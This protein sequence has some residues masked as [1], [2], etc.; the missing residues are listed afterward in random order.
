MALL[1][2][3][4]L[5]ILPPLLTTLELLKPTSLLVGTLDAQDPGTP[6]H[7]SILFRIIPLLLKG[8]LPVPVSL[9][10]GRGDVVEA[11]DL[12]EPCRLFHLGWKVF[13]GLK[14][15]DHLGVGELGWEGTSFG[16]DGNSGGGRRWVHMVIRK[17][18]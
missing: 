13:E 11:S 6:L 5:A 12:R 1:E 4:T 8:S 10:E 18:V 7:T 16:R 9:V 2:N 17:G 15:L 14:D 3:H